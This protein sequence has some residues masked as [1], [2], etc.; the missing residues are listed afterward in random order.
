MLGRLVRYETR[1]T[2]TGAPGLNG[3]PGTRHYACILRADKKIVY[4]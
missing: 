3:F 2:S 4:Q 1:K